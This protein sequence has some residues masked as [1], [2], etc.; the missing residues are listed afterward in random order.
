MESGIYETIDH[1]AMDKGFNNIASTGKEVQQPS[2]KP[3][4]INLT[5]PGSSSESGYYNIESTADPKYL[6]I[7]NLGQISPLPEPGYLTILESG[8]DIYNTKDKV[9]ETL[10]PQ[11]TDRQAD[12]KEMLQSETIKKSLT[13]QNSSRFLKM[14][15][16]VRQQKSM[17]NK[18]IIILVIVGFFICLAVGTGV[19]FHFGI[20]KST[21]Y[22]G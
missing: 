11:V 1:Y 4:G 19:G 8:L 9:H 2:S 10:K 18:T 13:S 6:E 20:K 5:M 7:R 15:N 3:V 12:F 16:S 22:K 17:S 14:Q 21:T